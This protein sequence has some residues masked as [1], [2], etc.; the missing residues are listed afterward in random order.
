MKQLSEYYAQTLL[1][2][3]PKFGK[4]IFE[5]CTEN[6]LLCKMTF[7]KAFSNSA[8]VEYA[9]KKWEIKKE[10]WWKSTLLINEA[11]NETPIAKV[12][13]RLFKKSIIE[14]PQGEK[15]FIKFAAFR[16]ASFILTEL[17]NPIASIKKKFG[18]KD[19]SEVKIEYGARQL[20]KYPWLI[21]LDLYIEL[22]RRHQSAAH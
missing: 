3:Q 9:E 21:M 22:G 19:I 13:V 2:I 7:P 1:L 14:L 5:L 4:R 11:G 12:Q 17:E 16:S 10:K 6:E 20:D 8:I 18:W 15:L